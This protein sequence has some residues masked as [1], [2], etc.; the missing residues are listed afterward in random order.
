[1][2]STALTATRVTTLGTRAYTPSAGGGVPSASQALRM[3]AGKAL[4]MGAGK[5]LKMPL[6][7]TIHDGMY[8]AQ[9]MT[10]GAAQVTYGA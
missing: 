9:T 6:S 8:G 3:G 5:A 4:R 1:M 7:A 2:L 10:Y